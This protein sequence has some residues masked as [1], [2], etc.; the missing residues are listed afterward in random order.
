LLG[1]VGAAAAPRDASYAF[2]DFNIEA[3]LPNNVVETI[4]QTRDGYLWVGTES[5]LARFDGVGFETFRASTTPGL[6]DNLARCIYEDRDGSLW[7]GTQGGLTR[8]SRGR[9]EVVGLAGAQVSAIA[10]ESSGRIWIATEGEGLWEYAGGRLVSHARDPNMPADG[11]ISRVCVDSEDRVWVSLHDHGLLCGL[12]GVF[13]PV[14]GLGATLPQVNQIAEAPRGTLWFGTSGGLYRYRDGQFKLLGR[15]QGLASDTVTG[16]FTDASGRLWVSARALYVLSDPDAG[17]FTRVVVPPTEYCHSVMQDREGSYWLAT[18][19]DGIVQMRASAFRMVTSQDGLPKG[20]MRSVS[21]DAAGN[22][23][24]GVSTHGLARIAPD[25]KIT[26]TPVGTGPDADIWSVFAAP[27]GGVWVGTRGPLHRWRNGAWEDYPAVRNV[28]VAYQDRTGAMWFGPADGGVVRYRDGAFE[29]LGS[30]LGLPKGVAMA[31]AE[32]RVGTLY[33][34]FQDDGIVVL[35]D[36]VETRILRANSGLPDDGIRAIYPDPDGSLWVGTKRRGLTVRIDGR[37]ANP[38]AFRDPFGDLVDSIFERSGK[39]WL[40]T[41]LGIFWADKAEL[42]AAARGEARPL[43]L[44]HAGTGQGVRVAGVGFGTQPGAVRAPDGSMW[45][46]T[47][48]G[49]VRVMPDDLRMNE[50]PPPV[51]IERVAVDGKPVTAGSEIR[52]PPGARTLVIDYTALTFVD[53]SRIAF[54]YELVGHDARWVNAGTR[55][56]AYYNNL[57][58]GT[59]TF[60]V[61]ARNEDGR[62]NNVGASLVLKQEPWFYQTWWFFGSV[63]LGILIL[64]HGF[65]LWRTAA[66][67]RE[68]LLL[69]ERVAERTRELVRAKEGAEAATRAKSMF[70]ANMSHEIRT[71]MNGVIG[72]AGLLLET[73]LNEEQRDYA[74]TVRKSGEALLGVINDILDFSK[75][76]AGR[77]VIE[78]IEFDPRAAVEDVLEILAEAAMKKRLELACWADDEVP[79]EVVGDPGRFRQVLLNLVGN[80]IKFTDSGEVFVQVSAQSTPNGSRLHVQVRDTGIGLPA[81]AQSR[82]FQSFTQG[83]DST[84]RRF[85]GTGL[86][87]AISKQLV[88]AMG[89]SIGVESAPGQGS[90]FW[91][92]IEVGRAASRPAAPADALAGLRGRRVLVVDD[93][94]INRRILTQLLRR[95]GAVPREARDAASAERELAEA[96]GQ[97]APFELAILDFHMPGKD[98][99]ELASTI[100]SDP[101]LGQIALIL[102]SSCLTHEHRVQAE[103]L[104][105]AAVFQKPFRQPLLLRALQKLWDPALAA[106]T[107]AASQPDPLPGRPASILIVEDNPTNQKLAQRMVEKL[108]HRAEVVSNGREALEALERARHDLVLMDCQMPVM[109]GYEATVEIRRREAGT[110]ARIPVVAM[111]ANAIEGEREH[112]LAA[113]MDD[114]LAKP[115]KLADLSAAIRR[116]TAAATAAR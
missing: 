91:F 55:R 76:E 54:R 99:L 14:P 111:T 104:G 71:P 79:A 67:R 116:W 23:W 93:H 72:M 88:E 10:A 58:P 92:E 8:Y 82:L 15:D 97:G 94:E 6:A 106:S 65:Y 16:C 27:D 35:R 108:G 98:G 24:T 69:E 9:F 19:G 73:P 114:Y 90:T 110:G 63:A 43:T 87:L 2:S 40:G 49:L 85:G 41:T 107:P 42:L 20:S 96:V 105:F 66:L 33:I 74:Q 53:P 112:C 84:T 64:G 47:R 28:R 75:I 46:S 38:D 29:D 3:G 21:A 36:G 56:T 113:G 26:L 60:R 32:D 103:R 61:I 50:V 57:S 115:V 4:V 100:R 48:T 80:A 81:A 52:L 44:H 101:S 34:G 18:S 70:L 83:D 51:Q 11:W 77:L 17:L 102:L 25:G 45:F 22:I 78:R 109:D 1:S 86:G 89:G 68:K 30:K 5:G 31:F 13:R 95:W 59:Y 12:G 39:F 62:A 37:W 7:I